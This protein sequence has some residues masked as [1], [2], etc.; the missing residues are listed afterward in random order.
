M[1]ILF[2]TGANGDI[3]KEICKYFKEKEW[4]II[5]T[6]IQNKKNNYIDK[7]Y[8]VNLIDNGSIK[9]MM[10]DIYN[11]FKNINKLCVIN[12]AAYQCCKPV[13]EYSIDEWDNSYKCNVRAIFLIIKYGIELLKLYDVNIINI[14]SVHSICTSKNIA[15]YASTK[16][17]ITG[18]TKNL[19]IDLA[20]FNVRVNCISPGAINTKMLKA[21]LNKEQL[22]TLISK[23]P[24]KKIGE[25]QQIAETCWFINNNT[26]ING[27]N[28][29]IDG[30]ITSK[31]SSE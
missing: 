29:I 18:L 8:S 4:M 2:L 31:L 7:Y 21:H 19:A 15:S 5:G 12:C 26:F 25:S 11:S 3:G 30:G 27:S 9:N 14:S 16:A 20:D 28:L 1:N 6:D 17:A 13:W 10:S 23:H 22:D 24:L